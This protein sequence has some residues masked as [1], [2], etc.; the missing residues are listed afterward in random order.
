MFQPYPLSPPEKCPTWN[1][2]PAVP[3]VPAVPDVP[4]V[5]A[6]PAVCLCTVGAS[7]LAPPPTP[8]WVGCTGGEHLLLQR[9]VL[10]LSIAS[11]LPA[12]MAPLDSNSGGI[13]WHPSDIPEFKL[14]PSIPPHKNFEP[15]PSRYTAAHTSFI[16]RS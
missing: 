3:A 7:T 10:L 15:S 11:E 4:A 2:S 9:H 6:V 12:A 16:V 5:P 8:L 14:D 13:G 1:R